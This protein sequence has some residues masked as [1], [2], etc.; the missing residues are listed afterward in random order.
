MT[1]EAA[2][3]LQGYKCVITAQA[4]DVEGLSEACHEMPCT[5][6]RP[7]YGA[8]L[9]ASDPA[10]LRQAMQMQEQVKSAMIAEAAK[11]KEVSVT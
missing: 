5:G 8:K 4:S 6:S 2:E 1:E 11:C 7:T 9:Y 10:P 3:R